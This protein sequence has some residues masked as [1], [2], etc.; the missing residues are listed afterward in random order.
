[1]NTGSDNSSRDEGRSY[2]DEGS[3]G[4][5]EHRGRR[6]GKEEEEEKEEEG[7]KLALVLVEGRKSEI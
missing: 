1:M 4:L 7:W 5:N 6:R 3:N 2:S